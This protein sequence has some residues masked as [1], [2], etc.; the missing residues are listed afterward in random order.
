MAPPRGSLAFTFAF[1]GGAILAMLST[2]MI[3]EG[4]ENAGRAAGLVVT[5]GFAVSYGITWLAD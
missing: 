1:A 2:T 4:Y 3:P 5:L